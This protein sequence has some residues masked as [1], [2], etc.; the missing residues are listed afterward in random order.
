MPKS[1]VQSLL[2]LPM[3]NSD[4]VLYIMANMLKHAL[5]VVG[6][7]RSAALYNASLLAVELATDELLYV[8]AHAEKW[9][10]DTVEDGEEALATM[11]L[12]YH[13]K[14]LKMLRPKEPYTVQVSDF[15]LANAMLYLTNLY[16]IACDELDTQIA[17]EVS[18]RTGEVKRL[19]PPNKNAT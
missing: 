12:R 17:A 16:D 9:D 3:G 14:V 18:L 13:K 4:N 11:R 1:F 6:Q 19:P 2:R 5:C 10:E 8:R 7:G 15:R